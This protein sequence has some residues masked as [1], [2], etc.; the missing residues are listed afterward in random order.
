MSIFY[1]FK[2]IIIYFVAKVKEKTMANKKFLLGIMVLVLLFGMTAV[3]CDNGSTGGGVNN[4]STSSS[5]VGTWK[6]TYG[7]VQI[8]LVFNANG[9]FTQSY[10]G[11]GTI[12]GTYIV[13]G[14]TVSLTTGGATET[15]TINGNRITDSY[16]VVYTRQ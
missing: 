2:R 6:A 9:T 7:G 8:T 1:E 16:G 5:I 13:S 15:G 12:S 4:G 11:A 3:S 14:N 10:S